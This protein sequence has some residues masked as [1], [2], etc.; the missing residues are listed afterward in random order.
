MRKRKRTIP[1]LAQLYRYY[2]RKYFKNKL[3][4]I[5]VQYGKL[6]C[7]S[8]GATDFWAE[9]PV[10]ITINKRYKGYGRITR[11]ILLHEM[12]HVSLPFDAGHGPRHQNGI[13]RLVRLG[14]YA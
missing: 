3:P 12:V 11:T 7:K 8:G 6:P 13:M 4:K 2:N 9:D 10:A 5:S 1:T 14:A